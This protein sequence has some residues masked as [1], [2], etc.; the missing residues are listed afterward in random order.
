MNSQG[1]STILQHPVKNYSSHFADDK[2]KAMLSVHVP[3]QIQVA[4]N[5]TT[6]SHCEQLQLM[7]F[8]YITP[9]QELRY[10]LPRGSSWLRFS[11][12]LAVSGIWE[13]EP[14]DGKSILPCHSAFQMFLK[15][16][17]N[18]LD[19]ANQPRELPVSLF[20][21]SHFLQGVT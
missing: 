10:E 9:S 5:H 16:I 21:A 7:P 3:G 19:D 17:L 11:P 14:A 6:A 18:Y 20:P 12:A 2:T 8:I 1:F 15:K 4:V 13:S